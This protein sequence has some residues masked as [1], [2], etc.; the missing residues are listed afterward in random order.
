MKTRL[1]A[2]SF[3]SCDPEP[4]ESTWT[5]LRSNQQLPRTNLLLRH[6]KPLNPQLTFPRVLPDSRPHAQAT[7]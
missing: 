1:S 2:V 4:S 3:G 6:N 5:P 7:H